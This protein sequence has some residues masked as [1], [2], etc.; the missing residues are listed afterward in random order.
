M[1]TFVLGNSANRP[2]LEALAKASNGF[3]VNISNSDDIVGSVAV[4]D[5]QGDTS[6]SAWCEDRD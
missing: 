4:G 5:F 6:S 3:A 1:F 2:L